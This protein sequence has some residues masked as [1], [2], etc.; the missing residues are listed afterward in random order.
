MKL[1]SLIITIL[2]LTCLGLI[3]L[4]EQTEAAGTSLFYPDAGA[5]LNTNQPQLQWSATG[6]S[7]NYRYQI[8]TVNTFDSANLTMGTTSVNYL[9]IWFPLNET[10][11]FWRVQSYNDNDGWGPYS[12]YRYFFIDTIA[13]AIPT[14]TSPLNG[15]TIPYDEP[16]LAWID[17]ID[18]Y[19]YQVQ[20]S[21][22]SDFTYLFLY[23]AQTDNYYSFVDH[24]DEGQWFWRV[25]GRDYADNYCN[26]TSANFTIDITPPGIPVLEAPDN[27]AILGD[28]QPLLDWSSI[29][30]SLYQVQV[31]D[32]MNFSTLTINVTT[33]DSFYQIP[34][35]LA[36]GVWYWR[37]RG[38]DNASNWGYWSAIWW[39]KVDTVVV[40]ELR[41]VNLFDN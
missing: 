36:D 5:Y 25:R 13:P 17:D 22:T 29:D 35:A 40:S 30:A 38:R 21:N 20:M 12:L 8:D 4:C 41:S 11:Y 26:W 32:I 7:P 33:S 31:S 24:L 2:I 9:N 39:F 10:R 28:N 3:V 14:I 6:P 19:Q 18:V 1:K 34:A 37:V 23:Q 27:L 16:T 15:T